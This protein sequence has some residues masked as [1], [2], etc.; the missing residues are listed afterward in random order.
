MKKTIFLI[1]GHYSPAQALVNSLQKN[2]NLKI[3]YLGRKY[4]L[5]GDGAVSLEFQEMK[6][7]S[8]VKFVQLTTGRLQRNFTIYTIPSLMKIPIGLIESFFFI[9]KYHPVLIFS[10]GG[11]LAIPVVIAGYILK[12]PI[13]H[14]EQVPV[15]DFP[16]RFLSLLSDKVLVSHQNLIPKNNPNEKW[17]LT[18]NPVRQEI[19]RI[20]FTPELEKLRVLAKKL[21]LPV[22]Y[23]TGGSQGSH[24]IN[25]LVLE[26]LDEL[27]KGHLLIWQTGDSQ[28][29]KDYDRNLEKIKKLPPDLQ[30]RIYLRKFILSEEIG[31]VFDL[32]DYVIA[33]SG[34][35]TVNELK[36]LGK[37][38]I[39]IPIPW[40]HDAEQLKNAQMLQNLGM[41][42]VLDQE[43][44][45][46]NS[47]LTTI[48]HFDSN[49]KKYQLAAHSVK[50]TTSDTSV[51]IVKMIQKWLDKP[52]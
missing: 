3:V 11:Y 4:S 46:P 43:K 5:E 41:A 34:A 27:A 37:P 13:F 17:V 15:L 20:H 6:N 26:N 2:Q 24:L 48:S 33:R 49:F 28:Q 8:S 29:F 47:F 38:A 30:K 14:H 32:S 31:A 18:G 36:S 42:E 7:V 21:K 40:V 22:L 45:N 23:I 52:K 50:K 51:I 25:S 35:N 9:L 16:S 10:F 39:L 44:V 19:Y 12:V 1:G